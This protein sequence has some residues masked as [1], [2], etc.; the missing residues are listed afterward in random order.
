[1]AVNRRVKHARIILFLGAPGSGK[2]T[3]SVRLSTQLGIPC[4]STG[5]ML[6][7]EAKTKTPAGLRLRRVLASGSLV[8]DSTV[9]KVA[10]ARLR[11]EAER[12]F[13]AGGLILDGFPR[14]LNQARFLDRLLS[15]LGLSRP[16]V[17]HLDVSAHGLLTRLSARRQ[18]AECGAIYNLVTNPSRLGTSCEIDGG[19]LVARDDDS[20]GVV[21]KR[22]EEFERLSAPLIDYYASADYHCIDG[23]RESDTVSFDLMGVLTPQET[24]LAACGD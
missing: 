19:N 11:R 16:T 22:L 10:G 21:L 3:Q 7:S 6:R 13:P 17:I 15:E 18:C 12:G 23:D 14:T 9:L 4:L 20:E 2:G 5:E 1:M 8:S 24:Y